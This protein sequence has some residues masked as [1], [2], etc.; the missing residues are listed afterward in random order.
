M[1]ASHFVANISAARH[2]PSAT[3]QAQ[4]RP[5]SRRTLS[6]GPDWQQQ[7]NRSCLADGACDRNCI[8]A[9]ACPVREALAGRHNELLVGCVHIHCRV[10]LLRPVRHARV[11]VRV[12]HRDSPDAAQAADVRARVVVQH[13]D[14]VPQDVALAC[15]NEYLGLDIIL[16]VDMLPGQSMRGTGVA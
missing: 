9:R 6:I 14:A 2:R 8:S 4:A 5:A 13:H 11:E 7:T 10:K 1:P 15:G 12:R 16:S 3:L